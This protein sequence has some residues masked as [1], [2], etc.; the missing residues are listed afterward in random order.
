MSRWGVWRAELRE[1]RRRQREIERR[2]AGG[3]TGFPKPTTC[4]IETA[5]AE[6]HKSGAFGA[7]ERMP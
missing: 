7:K 5:L 3:A 6:C 4:F 1:G 2:V